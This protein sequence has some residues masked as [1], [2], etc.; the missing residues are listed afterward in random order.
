MDWNANGRGRNKEERD[1]QRRAE[2]EGKEASPRDIL[3]FEDFDLAAT[4]ARSDGTRIITR[5]LTAGP[6]DYY[7]YLA[8]ADPASPKP[9]PFSV[10]RKR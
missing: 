10:V 4:S 1:K 6:G 8:W 9:P 7:L 2:L 5:A 3:P